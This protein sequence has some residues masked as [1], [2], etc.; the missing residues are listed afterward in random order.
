MMT[1]IYKCN[2]CKKKGHLARKCRK[3]VREGQ[4]QSTF[5]VGERKNSPD[6]LPDQGLNVSSRNSAQLYATITM[7]SYPFSMEINT[8]V[9]VS[10]V[11]LE[12]FNAIQEGEVNTRA[13]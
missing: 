9:S 4:G 2:Y 8:G 10:I 13:G 11:S 1:K 12:I 6:G 3:Q 7:N 5:R